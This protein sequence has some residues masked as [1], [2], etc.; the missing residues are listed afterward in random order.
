MKCHGSRPWDTAIQAG[1]LCAR[2]GCILKKLHMGN[3]AKRAWR[4]NSASGAH[5]LKIHLVFS[6]LTFSA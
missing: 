4:F 1:V 2:T 5:V 6:I 3:F